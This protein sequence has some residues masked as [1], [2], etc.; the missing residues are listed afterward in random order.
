MR[1]VRAD[2]GPGGLL[3]HRRDAYGNPLIGSAFTLHAGDAV[4]EGV[5]VSTGFL[6][7][8]AD[9]Q[10][11][12]GDGGAAGGGQDSGSLPAVDPA[13]PGALPD[14]ADLTVDEVADALE[15][16][17]DD[18]VRAVLDAE[19]AGSARKGIL[20]GPAAKRINYS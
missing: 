16:L 10:V 17:G 6:D 11:V 20:H 3:V 15:A 8:G 1:R 9:G 14:P 7:E 19:K 2:V 12:E 13:A 5:E 18:A 4:P